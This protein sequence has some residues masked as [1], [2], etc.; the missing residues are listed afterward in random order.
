MT[1]A[2]RNTWPTSPTARARRSCCKFW[3]K[4]QKKDTQARLDTFL[5]GMRPTPIRLAAVHRYLLPNASQDS[6]NPFVRAHLN[7][8]KSQRETHRRAPA[9]A[10]QSLRPRYL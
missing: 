3:K 10:L 8:I 5:D 7:G 9:K 2:A 6:F 1:R 4:Y